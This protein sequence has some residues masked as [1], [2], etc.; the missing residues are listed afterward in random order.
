MQYRCELGFSGPVIGVV[1]VSRHYRA[2]CFELG[3]P[4]IQRRFGDTFLASELSYGV[5]EWRE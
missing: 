3:A 4:S 2:S 5:V 1:L